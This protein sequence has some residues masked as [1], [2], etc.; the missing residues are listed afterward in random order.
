MP[1]PFEIGRGV[2]EN[3]SGAFAQQRS[4]TALDDILAQAS[5]SNDPRAFDVLS[6]EL[7]KYVSPHQQA[8]AAQLLQNKKSELMANRKTQQQQQAY[9]A[10]GLDPSMANLD[11]SIQRELIKNQQQ[12]T[13]D[14]SKKKQILQD[15]FTGSE[16]LLKGGYT[17]KFT[18]GGL[19]PEGRRQRAEFDGLAEVFISQ[20]IPLLNPRGNM[21]QARFDYIKSLVPSSDYTDA[22][23]EGKLKAL[24]KIFAGD[25]SEVE[26]DTIEMTSPDGHIADIPKENE[27]QARAQGYK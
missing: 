24:R 6:G 23:N 27:A 5:Q 12:K 19:T 9:Q 16:E 2:S 21:S 1:S 13:V 22:T 4:N 11:P 20:L 25:L 8:G 14:D 26:L 17:G 18:S 3:I 7:M 15:A 10:Q